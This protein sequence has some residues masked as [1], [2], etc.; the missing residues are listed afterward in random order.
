MVDEGGSGAARASSSSPTGPRTPRCRKP[1]RRLP[2]STS[3]QTSTACCDW[4]AP[5]NERHARA[6]HQPLARTD[7]GLPRPAARSRTDWTPITLLEGGTPLIHATRL[8]E[9]TGCTGV[10]QGRGAQP[11][12]FVQGPRHDDG[13]HRRRGPRPEGRAVRVDRQ[14]LGIGRGLRRARGHHLRRADPAGQDRDGQAGPGGHARR[15]DHSDRRQLRRLPRAGPQA[16]RRL[17]DDR[18]W[19][20]RSTRS[21]SRGRR[22]RRSRSSTPSARPPTCTRCPSATRATSPRT[23]RAT[24]STTATAWRTKLPRML[25]TQAAGAAPL[26]LGE[27]V[28]QPGDHRDRHPHRLAGVVELGR[29]GP[30]GVQRP[31]PRRDRRGDPRRVPPGRRA[32]KGSSSSPR[33]P[34]ASPACSSRI[35][36]GWVD[37]GLHRGV[38]RH[39]QRAQGPRHRAEGAAARHRRSPVDPV[40]VAAELG[41]A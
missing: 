20:T 37:A 12:R 1:L 38:H 2:I 36:D 28:K 17:P 22:P 27:P 21:A 40:A 16:D 31:L 29:R 4:K 10:P 18:R 41:L 5:T 19:S 25:G 14:H 9:T 34:P 24:P 32:A 23:G 35:D 8:S 30:A 26:V 13:R 6:V 11:D 3:C 7:R 33:R 39:R 15:Q